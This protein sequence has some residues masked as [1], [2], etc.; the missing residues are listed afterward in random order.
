MRR[1]APRPAGP[2]SRRPPPPPPPPAAWPAPRR[3][4][5]SWPG[6]AAIILIA[7]MLL[8]PAADYAR[9]YA[10]AQALQFVVF[11][12]A[13]PALL[14]L[15]IPRRIRPPRLPG[16]GQHLRPAARAAIRLAAF[17]ALAITWRLPA[18]VNALARHPVL[19]ARSS[20]G[21]GAAPAPPGTSARPHQPTRPEAGLARCE[22]GA[23]R[24]PDDHSSPA[25]VHGLSGEAGTG[26]LTRLPRARV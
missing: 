4:S 9:Q 15:A 10:F 21:W 23:R 16:A 13:G 5:G 11:A 6:I 12:V 22:A 26:R 18:T 8:P 19:T 7:S 24:T 25:G 2:R 3:Y 1:P 17:T 20:P 14:V